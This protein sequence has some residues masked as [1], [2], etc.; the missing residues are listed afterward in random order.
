MSALLDFVLTLDRLKSVDRRNS[1]AGGARFENTAEHSWHAAT[2]ALVLREAC[3]FPVDA[4]RA[5]RMLLLHDVPEI[6]CGD[7]FLYDAARADASQSEALALDRLLTG[8]P[9]D[10]AAEMKALWHEFTD[11]VTP[12]AR[13]AYAIDRLMPVLLNIA[14]DGDVWRRHG[15]SRDR[16]LAMNQPV[17]E[18]FPSLWPM[19]R[20]R[21]EAIFDRIDGGA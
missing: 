1:V 3:A 17:A 10:A 2:M 12:E 9:A 4:H 5:S 21:I 6:E 7:T 18:V 20:A 16:V 11:A 19:V 14:N 15:V 13:Y 8:L